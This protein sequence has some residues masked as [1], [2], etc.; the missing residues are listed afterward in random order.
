MR[1]ALPVNWLDELDESI[2]GLTARQ[3]VGIVALAA[4]VVVARVVVTT[5]IRILL[6]RR[7]SGDE[8]T[9]WNSERKRID[10]ALSLLVLGIVVV[11]GTPA[12]GVDADLTDVIV[13]AGG[14]V[15]V[16]GA[17][18][19]AYRLVDVVVDVLQRRAAL[20]ESKLDDGL[21]PLL[22]TVLRLFV[23]G[24]GVIFALQNLD[25]DVSSL[26]TG[27][28]LGGLAFALAAQ[29]TARNLFGGV[30][31]FVDKPFE[32]GDWIE[33]DGIE[34]TVEAVGFR[35]TRIRTFYN[36]QVT[37]P[38]GRLVDTGVDNLGRR[39]WRRYKTN[40]G[41]GYHSTTDQVEA[42]VE[43]VRD[44]IQ[45][46]DGFRQD[47]FIVE[48]V[49]FGESSLD[50]MLYCFIGAPDW[51]AELR[52]RH[53][54]NLDIMRVAERVGVEFAFPTRTVHL[55]DRAPLTPE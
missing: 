7:F 55:P 43:G 29:D 10:R 4:I 8:L 35:S 54:L 6:R 50:V 26:L 13:R 40:L 39:E 17:I 49:G 22:R 12:L 33:V 2:A 5:V 30:T 44:L 20:T 23:M 19:L 47:Y 45:G 34:G 15:A 27:L 16:V 37:V 38:N 51:N 41:I 36:S 18:I 42:F 32:I 3:L 1:S 52:A 24:V 48:F 14:F 46:R 9:F 53:E 28:G 31:V 25:V 21:V 11:V